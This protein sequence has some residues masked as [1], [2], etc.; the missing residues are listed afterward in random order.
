MT[1]LFTDSSAYWGDA[2]VT[3]V[4]SATT[5]QYAHPGADL[6]AQATPGVVALAYVAVLDNAMNTHLIDISYDKVGENGRFNN[7]FDLWDDENATIQH[8]NNQGYH[9]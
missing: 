3:A 7:F 5:F 8:F 9:P 4:P 2:V 6:A 1:I